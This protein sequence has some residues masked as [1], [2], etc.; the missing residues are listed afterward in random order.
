MRRKTVFGVAGLAL[1]LIGVAGGLLAW[2][3]RDSV[4]TPSAVL[5]S[6]TP[7]IVLWAWE[8]PEDLRFLKGERVGIAFLA[9]TV[10]I[11]RDQDRNG[12][13]VF[14]NVSVVPRMQP[15]RVADGTPVIAVVRVETV[16]TKA[17][18]KQYSTGSSAQD[19]SGRVANEI[20][21][22]ANLP[23]VS[24]VQIDFDA[25]ARE[26]DFYKQLL[27][28]TRKELP[29]RFPIS[30]TALA[31]WCTHD[32]WIEDLPI[33]TI[34]EAVPMLFR[35][36]VGT[37]NVEILL[38][39]GQDFSPACAQSTGVSNDES[40]SLK[41][42]R[43]EFSEQNAGLKRSRIYVFSPRAWDETTARSILEELQQW[44]EK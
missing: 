14:S 35:M 39:R 24:A 27:Q 20:A 15:L 5:M 17:S 21:S 25:L 40:T 22:V 44:H 36:G 2:P 42:L 33:G 43:G 13:P 34:D 19:V 9:R 32:T 4:S 16:P 3:K 41:F 6:Q 10:R 26:R 29:A 28:E 31:S 1:V 18:S 37:K 23:N 38:K 11:T 12:L 7:K 8:R 30:I